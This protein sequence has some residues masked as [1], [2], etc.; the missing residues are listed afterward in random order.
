MK[1]KILALFLARGGSKR[2]KNK[3]I[4]KFEKKPIIIHSLNKVKSSKIFQNIHVST[5]SKKI[6]KIVKKYGFKIDFKRPIY[7]SK[8]KISS[9][10]VMKYVIRK[11]LSQGTKYDIIFNIMPASPLLE[12]YDLKKALRIFLKNKEELPLHV[13]TRFPV[14]IEWAVIKKK[15]I[16][17]AKFPDKITKDSKKF[18]STFYECGPFSIYSFKHIMNKKNFNVKNGFCY[19][20]IPIY[21]GVDIDDKDDLTMAKLLFHNKK[22]VNG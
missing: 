22:K 17:K 21:R 15:S 10:S 8:D 19:Y 11:Y 18:D 12:V 20:E 16:I 2:I 9:L 13:I 1:K 14:P 6:I 5:E 3:N 7:L 4:I